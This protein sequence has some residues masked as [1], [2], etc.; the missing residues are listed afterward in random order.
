VFPIATLGF[1]GAV[2]GVYILIL[3]FGD[4][5]ILSPPALDKDIP[6]MLGMTAIA[7]WL[8]GLLVFA[9]YHRDRASGASGFWL[10]RPMATRTLAVARLRAMARS[11][12]TVLAILTL[13]TLERLARE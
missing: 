9:V 2:L 10:R 12:A 6:G 8:A 11:I 1:I 5:S 7:A 13:F 4:E 3:I